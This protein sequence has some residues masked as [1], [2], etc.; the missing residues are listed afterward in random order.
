[1]VT[2]ADFCRAWWTRAAQEEYLA[3]LS[4]DAPALIDY[5]KQSRLFVEKPN[6]YKNGELGK[7]LRKL[8]RYVYSIDQTQFVWSVFGATLFLFLSK[9]LVKL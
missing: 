8:H 4:K 3:P 7:M 2:Y 1:M 6:E 9:K 5:L